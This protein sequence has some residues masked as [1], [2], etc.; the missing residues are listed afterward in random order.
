MPKTCMAGGSV[1]HMGAPLTASAYIFLLLRVVALTAGGLAAN[2]N[3]K[4]LLKDAP[5][6]PHHIVLTSRGETLVQ[7]QE[8]E[9]TEAEPWELKESGVVPAGIPQFPRYESTAAPQEALVSEVNI[10]VGLSSG[11]PFRQSVKGSTPAG[12]IHIG[13]PPKELLVIFD[14][15]SDKLV[16]KTWETVQHE[17]ATVDGGVK[18]MVSP[19]PKLY[20]HNTSSTYRSRHMTVRNQTVPR[21][22]FIAYGSGIAITMEGTETVNVGHVQM[23]NISLSEIAA[24]SLS[25]LHTKKGISGVMGLQHMKNRT[26]GESIFSRLRDVGN[27]SAFGYCRA[28]KNDTGTFLWGDTATDGTEIEVIGEIHWA[29]T[30]ADVIVVEN[31]TSTKLQHK[32]EHDTTV[33]KMPLDA[34]K[35]RTS[36]LSGDAANSAGSEGPFWPFGAAGGGAGGIIRESGD[37]LGGSIGGSPYVPIHSGHVPSDS[38]SDDEGSFGGTFSGSVP[39]SPFAD[40]RDDVEESS[41]SATSVPKMCP[42]GNCTV[43]LDTGSNIIAGPS[44]AL[45]KLVS[46]LKVK[47]DC[48]NFH[49]LPA[50]QLTVG[51]FNV[52]V[53]PSSYIMKVKLPKWARWAPLH[54]HAHGKRTFQDDLPEMGDGEE[55]QNVGASSNPLSSEDAG[56]GLWQ[57]AVQSLVEERGIDLRTA[58]EGILRNMSGTTDMCMPAI[59][60]LNKHTKFGPLWVIGTPL[61]DGYYAR[62]SWAKNK[63]SP[64]IFLKTVGTAE[65]CNPSLLATATS[66]ALPP[67]LAPT[68]APVAA[69]TS[70]QALPLLEKV[71]GQR[72]M[73]TESRTVLTAPLADELEEPMVRE[74]DDITFPHWALELDAL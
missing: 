70:T 8:A 25:L 45:K 60:P 71:S 27:M 47:S 36:L 35:T 52:T 66:G 44:T 31:E 16:A 51:G 2:A 4:G 14:T 42:G 19:S 63:S 12:I 65:A 3:A 34:D 62:W 56:A 33:M 23:K 48:S 41:S 73:R 11:L 54:R 58:L 5:L 46:H 49:S 30:L 67:S 64:S 37:G 59:V 15:G 20:N 39:L 43:I 17:L 18:G 21:R 69:P 22:G 68:A 38:S 53:P 72:L 6:E 7:R 57:S 55:T 74:L 32:R 1:T 24:D 13:T 61:L 28:H 9:R 40:A 50:L 26:V 10:S 29:V